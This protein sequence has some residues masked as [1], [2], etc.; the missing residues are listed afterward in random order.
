M[1]AYSQGSTVSFKGLALGSL[2][3]WDVTPAAASTTDCTSLDSVLLGSGI[4]ARIVKSVDCCAVDP[5]TASVTFLGS[6]GFITNN[7]G[8]V[9]ELA[10]E[11]DA[12]SLALEAILQSF[13][14]TAAVGELIKGTATFQFTGQ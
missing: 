5:G 12:G 8:E 7:V 13:Q 11:S 14:I 3:G 4:E 6:N 10:I 1:P 2:L 9:G